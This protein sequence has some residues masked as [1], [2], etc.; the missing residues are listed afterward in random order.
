MI[1]ATD[2]KLLVKTLGPCWE[3]TR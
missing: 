1:G 3:A 2:C